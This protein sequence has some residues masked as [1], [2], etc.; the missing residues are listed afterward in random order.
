[1]LIAC[2]HQGYE[3]YG[4]DRAFIEAVLALRA[5]FPSARIEIVL[6]Q[7]GPLGREFE[8][9]SLPVIIDELWILRR[10]RLARLVTA[11]LPRLPGR[12]SAARRRI[13]RA[14]LTYINTAVP[15]DHLLAARLSR[16]PV[17]IHVHELPAGAALR[18]FRALLRVSRATLIANSRATARAF[19]LPMAVVPNGAVSVTTAPAHYDGKRKLRVLMLG[20]IHPQKGQAV[21]LEAVAHLSP[22]VRGRIAVRIAGGA[23]EAP[24]AERG[25]RDDVAARGVDDTVTVEPF[26]DD[27]T[28]LFQW[29]DVVVVP[30]RWGESLGRVAIE[31]MAHGRVPV[32]SATGGLVEVV[33]DGR[34]GYLVPPGRADALADRLGRMI[35]DPLAWSAMPAAA[36][37]RYRAEYSAERT[38]PALCAIAARAMGL[39]LP[40]AA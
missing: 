18:V 29:A 36:Q 14:D 37:A 40:T 13:E 34:T 19:G 3:L 31:A 16:R 6:P 7:D 25:L 9:L 24:E 20:R 32:V 1:M 2:V 5:G 39:T 10:T 38:G 17:L 4:S 15:L 23:F 8:R 35:T 22:E 28:P 26:V 12:V 30:S 33:D 11:G 27:P 21:L